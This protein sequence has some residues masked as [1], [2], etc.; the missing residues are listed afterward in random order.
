MQQRDY[1][2]Y[3][4]GLVWCHV[5]LISIR[6]SHAQGVSSFYVAFVLAPF[7][8]NGSELIAAYNYAVKKTSKTISISLTTLEGAACMNNTFGLGIFM[9]LIYLQGLAWEYLAE[10]LAILLAQVCAV[11]C[12]RSS[13]M[14]R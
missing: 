9:I 4:F 2:L 10:T 7:A 5:S 11:T 8:S 6:A 3:W 12:R 14:F 1:A 13:N